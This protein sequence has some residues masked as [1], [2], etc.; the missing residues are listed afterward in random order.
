MKEYLNR[1]L[2]KYELAEAVAKIYDYKKVRIATADLLHSKMLGYSESLMEWFDDNPEIY[3]PYKEWL[4]SG[5]STQNLG[6]CGWRISYYAQKAVDAVVY[7]V[8]NKDK[9]K[10]KNG[11]VTTQNIAKIMHAMLVADLFFRNDHS[12]NINKDYCYPKYRINDKFLKLAIPYEMLDVGNKQFLNDW[13]FFSVNVYNNLEEKSKVNLLDN[14]DTAFVQE[15]HR[16]GYADKPYHW[17]QV[18][19][20]ILELEESGRINDILKMLESEYL[21]TGYKWCDDFKTLI[22]KNQDFEYEQILENDPELRDL[23]EEYNRNFSPKIKKDDF[24]EDE[25]M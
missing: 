8:K 24:D 6:R 25:K 16:R 18:F 12:D 1:Q 15:D 19:D 20:K 2:T 9:I 17:Y 10:D 3:M 7:C 11:N 4:S 23:V 14:F 22:N 21:K 13:V 5:D